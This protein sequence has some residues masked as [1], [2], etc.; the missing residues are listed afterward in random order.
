MEHHDMK[1]SEHHSSMDH[2]SVGH[3]HMDHNDMHKEE[4][5]AH[6]SH[7]MPAMDHM[8]KMYFHGGFT[9]VILFD[10]WRINSIGGLIGSMI[11]CFLMGVLYEG[12]KA[13]R[14][15]WMRG[16][17]EEVSYNEVRDERRKRSDIPEEEGTSTSESPRDII[18]DQGSIKIIQTKMFSLPHI[19]LTVLH[20]L[21]MTLAYFLMLI[22]MTY[23]SWLCAAVIL[24]S[25]LGYFCFGWRKTSIVDVS[26][27]CH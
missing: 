11:G 25:T 15:Y 10:F 7:H 6:S 5:G 14:E 21:Q 4:M 2:P 9:E 23:N 19:I 13:Y 22:V 8:M 20:M 16:A 26:D 12:I 24:G 17:F 27:H 18:S 1:H 3:H